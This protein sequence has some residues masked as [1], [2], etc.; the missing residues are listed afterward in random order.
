MFGSLIALFL[1]ILSNFKAETVCLNDS[2]GCMC[3]TMMKCDWVGNIYNNITEDICITSM[4]VSPGF[5]CDGV[6]CEENPS[7]HKD[8][9]IFEFTNFVK[10]Y[11]KKYGNYFNVLNHYEIFK[12]NYETIMKHNRYNHSWKMGN[13]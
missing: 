10:K 1:G 2:R 9:Y 13:Q 3:D 7:F 4:K 8:T 6:C 12:E 5:Y 11:E